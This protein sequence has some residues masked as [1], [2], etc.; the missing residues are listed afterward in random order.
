MTAAPAVI[1]ATARAA[2][3]GVRVA[4]LAVPFWKPS[5]DLGGFI[6][7]FAPDAFEHQRK[8]DGF[9]DVMGQWSH[10]RS[11]PLAS[12]NGR[13]LRLEVRAGGLY[14]E[15]DLP[16][17]MEYIAELV[18]RGDATEA[19]IAFRVLKDDWTTSG[20]VNLRT[21][22]KAELFE[23]S[24]VPLAAYPQTTAHVRSDDRDETDSASLTSYRHKLLRQQL[25]L[26]RP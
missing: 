4:G 2:K 19:S 6:E 12:T 13:T 16:R 21:V 9:A 23:V 5:H 25:E 7:T 3:R 17:S 1:A 8:R 22:T 10:E 18:D 14:Y 24:I 11:I 26:A 20:G 15:M